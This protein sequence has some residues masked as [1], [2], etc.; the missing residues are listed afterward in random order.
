MSRVRS[1]ARC[2]GR[3]NSFTWSADNIAGE[4]C[5]EQV[6]LWAQLYSQSNIAAAGRKR[7]TFAV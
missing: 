5:R 1:A 2:A 3:N 7:K 6:S 4:L